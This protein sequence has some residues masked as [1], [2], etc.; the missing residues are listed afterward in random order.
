MQDIEKEGAA[1]KLHLEVSDDEDDD[2]EQ[3]EAT[4]AATA[5]N[6]V[7]AAP[8]KIHIVETVVV[9]PRKPSLVH[10]NTLDVPDLALKA[11]RRWVL[12]Q[13]VTKRCRLSLL[14][15]SALV[16]RVQMRGDREGVA[17]S[18]PMSTVVHIT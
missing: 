18:Q 16:I 3:D 2:D 10:L 13:G 5:I 7:R 14:T 11:Q 8:A 6:G 12:Y 15:N 9:K 1:L 17:G 4:A